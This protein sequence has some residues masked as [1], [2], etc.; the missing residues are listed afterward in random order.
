M[1]SDDFEELRMKLSL[2]RP[3]LAM[4]GTLLWMSTGVAADESLLTSTAHRLALFESNGEVEAAVS[5]VA[6]LAEAPVE[7]GQLPVELGG[8]NEL[9]ATS[10]EPR[11]C[12][13]T[14]CMQCKAPSLSG[15]YHAEV[16][17]MWLRAHVLESAVGKL[18]EKYELSPR[19]ILG[20]EDACGFGA[21]AR[22][23]TYGRWTPNLEDDDDEI[24]FE[25]NVI[26]VEAISRFRMA[27]SDLVLSGGMRW[28][29]IEITFDDEEVNNDM[30]GVTFAADLRTSVC[31]ECNL[32]WAFVGGARWS[33]LG[34]DWDG[35]GGFIDPVRDDNVSVRE[36]YVGVEYFC[37][38]RD[39]DLY[40]RLKYEIQN[41]HSDA[42][43]QD[44]GTD[45]IGFLG[46]GIEIGM[47]F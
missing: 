12:G 27:R 23:W 22:Y 37:T 47:M 18:S 38:Y 44:A 20:Y 5:P 14:G 9:P 34:G 36:L 11:T 43:A 40:A 16:E 29:D 19:F 2:R 21:R 32:E 25:L 1:N 46:P 33:L 28:A 26:D 10:A 8:G 39:Y 7:E 13:G 24:R 4:A 3:L 17:L 41:W 45:S 35:D 30:P 31:R 6:F 15:V 42:I